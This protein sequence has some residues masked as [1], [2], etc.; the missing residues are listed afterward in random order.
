MANTFPSTIEPTIATQKQH[1]PRVKSIAFGNGY[2]Q[3][4]GDGINNNLEKWTISFILSDTD[5]QTVEDFFNTEGGY[6]YFNWTS[7]ENGATQKQYLC[8]S[9]SISSFGANKY[10]I[11]C[12]FNEWAGLT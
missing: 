7:P 3:I 6:N 12:V 11:S 2:L 9:W 10:Q 4:A 1:Q 8:P 5:K